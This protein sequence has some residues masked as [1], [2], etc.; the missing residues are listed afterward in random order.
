[1]ESNF[2]GTTVLAI[3]RNGKSAIGGDGQLSYGETIVK[4]SGKKIRRLHEGKVLAGFAGG[5]ADA[6]ALFDLFEK[7]LSEYPADITRA[8]IELAKEWRLD[9]SLRRLEADLIVMNKEKMFLISG[10]GEIIEPDDNVIALGSG[11]AYA[12][13]A[14]RALLGHTKLSAKEICRNALEIAADICV[15]TNRNLTIEEL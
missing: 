6:L 10:Q 14:A 8:A 12:L 13:A 5:I 2:Q 7:K 11:G 4:A 3:R 9:R 15:Y 1:M